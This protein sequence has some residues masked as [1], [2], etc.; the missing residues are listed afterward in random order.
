MIQGIVAREIKKT[1][2]QK[3]GPVGPRH[4][5]PRTNLWCELCQSATHTIDTCFKKRQVD[6]F[7]EDQK[8][9][10]EKNRKNETQ[11]DA[12]R[13]GEPSTSS[14]GIARVSQIGEEGSSVQL[15]YTPAV[16]SG[17]VFRKCMVN[18]GSEVN[19]LPLR[20][21]T[22]FGIPFDPCAIT[23][24]LGF[25]GASSAVEGMAH[26]SLRVEP[27]QTE[28]KAQFLVTGGVSGGPILGFPA[29]ESLGLTVN[30]ATRELVCKVSG[31]VVHCSAVSKN[32][33]N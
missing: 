6:R 7:Y 20:E 9:K 17:H 21:A 18:T 11:N 12:S 31:Q 25:N 22:R 3:G 32:S 2:Q 14:G 24:I 26:C 4:G 10:D 13:S 23:Q 28:T 1:F 19:V 16:I 29:L 30:C 33:K 15:L 27:C 5:P 8:E